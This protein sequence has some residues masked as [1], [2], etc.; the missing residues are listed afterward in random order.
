MVRLR[1]LLVLL[2]LPLVASCTQS[3]QAT[4]GLTP[5]AAPSTPASPS[6]VPS[7]AAPTAPA[8]IE[9]VSACSLIGVLIT[10]DRGDAAA[11][12]REMPLTVRNCGTEP[13]EVRGRP[14][15]VVL[16]EDGRPLKVAVVASSHYTPA[17]R[18]LVLKPGEAARSVLSWRNTVTNIGGWS[19]TGASLVVAVSVG[20]DRQLV[21]VPATLDLG[22]TGRLEASP[23]F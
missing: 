23:W 16:G 9:S 8:A 1:R 12:Y 15:I 4:G 3:W 17:P 13:Y 18:R 14:D 21:A 20:G 22:D 11:G 10:A 2:V 19:D 6:V 7:S 5:T